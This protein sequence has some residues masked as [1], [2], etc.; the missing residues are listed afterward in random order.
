LPVCGKDPAAPATKAGE[1][2]QALT[3]KLAPEIPVAPSVPAA[4][5]VVERRDKEPKPFLTT[6]L[7]LAIGFLAVI[8]AVLYLRAP[9]TRSPD[10]KTAAALP[11][12]QS[13]AGL[14]KTVN[15]KP[16]NCA[17]AAFS[18]TYKAETQSLMPMVDV[19]FMGPR[20]SSAAAEG[21]LRACIDVK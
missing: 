12:A 16:L 3:P 9:P 6:V 18:A 5:D 13:K 14:P 11:A 20:P 21:A 10:L 1:G 7:Q 2:P 8:V 19:V 17:G 4:T 15:A